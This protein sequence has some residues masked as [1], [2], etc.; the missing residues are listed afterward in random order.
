MSKEDRYLEILGNS[1]KVVSK[2]FEEGNVAVFQ[3]L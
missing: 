2:I 3:V 1:F